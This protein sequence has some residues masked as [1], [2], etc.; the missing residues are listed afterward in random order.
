MVG[1]TFMT[2]ATLEAYIGLL[3]NVIFDN[4][5]IIHCED[6]GALGGNPNFEART[7]LH[8]A[9]LKFAPPRMVVAKEREK[10][11]KKRVIQYFP[12][13][14]PGFAALFELDLAVYAS[15]K[16]RSATV[17]VCWRAMMRQRIIDLVAVQV[18]EVALAPPG[19][20]AELGRKDD[21][22]V[23]AM[24]GV[25]KSEHTQIRRTRSRESE[26]GWLRKLIPRL[27]VH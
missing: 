12:N 18:A 24:I 25:A 17:D 20:W 11:A 26:R 3:A 14:P 27:E 15:H 10:R 8:P 4:G 23:N 9:Y 7:A 1:H 16:V 5:A 19:L 22:E 21:V 2:S 6:E 13:T